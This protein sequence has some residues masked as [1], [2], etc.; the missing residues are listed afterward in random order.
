MSTI[1]HL[2]V[3]VFITVH[4]MT[5]HTSMQHFFCAFFSVI[6]TNKEDMHKNI[7]C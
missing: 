1:T 7:N 4:P 2:S 6:N 5:C 3:L